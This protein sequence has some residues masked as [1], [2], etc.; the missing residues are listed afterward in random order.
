[1]AKPAGFITYSKSGLSFF[2]KYL[3]KHRPLGRNHWD[4]VAGAYN[5]RAADR[6]FPADEVNSDDDGDDDSDDTDEINSALDDAND[7]NGRFD[8]FGVTATVL[9]QTGS[10]GSARV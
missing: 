4:I 2:S 3:K 1:M 10:S 7:D 5:Q 8:V 6:G 9:G